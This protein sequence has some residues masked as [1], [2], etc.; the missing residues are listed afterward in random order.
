MISN[1]IKVASDNYQCWSEALKQWIEQNYNIEKFGK[2]SWRRLLK[3]IAVVNRAKCKKLAA[4]HQLKSEL[5][6]GLCCVA[7]LQYDTT[8]QQPQLK[9]KANV[10]SPQQL[11]R[12]LTSVS[13][14]VIIK[15]RFQFI[16]HYILCEQFP[17][18]KY[19]MWRQNVGRPVQVQL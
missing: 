7:A 10:K 17:Q 6:D 13:L 18:L 11:V 16:I 8:L 1:S 4:N 9:M 12:I 15:S 5:T 3:A 2:P 14:L 19:I